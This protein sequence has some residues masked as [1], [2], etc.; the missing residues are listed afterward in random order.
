MLAGMTARFTVTAQAVRRM[1]DAAASKG[2]D[3]SDFFAA[4]G[5]DASR[6]ADPEARFPHAF[7]IAL[8]EELPRRTGDDAFGLH[9]AQREPRATHE[10]IEHV[11]RHAPTL[12]ECYRRFMRYQRLGHDSGS[13]L[14]EVD[15][16]VARLVHAWPGPGALPRHLNEF[17]VAML[18]VLGRRYLHEEWSPIEVSFPHPEPA[19]TR[20]LRRLFRAPLRFGRPA[21]ELVFDRALLERPSR[22]ADPSLGAVLD[23]Y[24][25]L[26]LEQLPA[27]DGFMDQ[28]R[29]AV[30]K[31]LDAG[32]PEAEDLARQ[33][34]LSRRSFF[35]RLKEQGT[36]Y[37]QLTDELRRDLTLRHLRDGR[38]SLSEIAFVLGYSEVSTFHRAFRRW[39]GQ[40]PKAYQRSQARP[41]RPRS[42]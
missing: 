1:V 10:V 26:L 12:G 30:L 34:G 35:R 27:Q 40:S 8:W 3:V 18:L 5:L 37:H 19:D 39:T 29:R 2:V 4:H 38:L 11:M 16:P 25:Q 15:P 14:L 28:V 36:S 41:R 7:T 17:V 6:L 21:S 22:S 13:Y 31:S 33:M 42:T 24:A 20:E 32:V 23:R 9:V